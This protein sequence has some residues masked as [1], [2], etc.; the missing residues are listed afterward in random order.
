MTLKNAN[1]HLKSLQNHPKISLT[2]FKTRY[3]TLEN[4]Y[5]E[6][7]PRELLYIIAI[8]PEASKIMENLTYEITNNQVNI[9]LKLMSCFNYFHLL[10]KQA[11]NCQIL[12]N[13]IANYKIFV[14]KFGGFVFL[15]LICNP[16]IKKRK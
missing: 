5:L 12:E 11:K 10:F 1:L 14:F 13:I 16:K 4:N 3:K 15:F 7:K 2:N 6:Q 9:M 8:L